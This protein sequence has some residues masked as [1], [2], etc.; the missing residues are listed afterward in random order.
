MDI[1]ISLYSHFYFDQ[2]IKSLKGVEI[3][4]SKFIKRKNFTMVSNRLLEKVACTSI[5]KNANKILWVIVRN[6]RGFDKKWDWISRSQFSKKTG[7]QKDNISRSIKELIYKGFIQKDGKNYA[8][9]KSLDLEK[10]SI[11][12]SSEVNI[13]YEGSQ[14]RPPQ[15]KYIQNKCIQNNDIPFDEIIN[16]LNLSA[17]KNF[18]S[19]TNST[20]ELIILRWEEGYR[21]DDFKKVIDKKVTG[22]KDNEKMN[23]YLRP[24]TLFGENF[25]SYLN[26]NTPIQKDIF[27]PYR[28]ID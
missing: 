24:Q 9:S 26:E 8:I 25:E 20:R 23:Q 28:R 6:T 15:N 4:I 21:L 19:T 12:T 1:T 17:G 16:Y 5:T 27:R 11:E 2:K 14:N 13:D 3:Q 18:K 10:E 22:W 7:I